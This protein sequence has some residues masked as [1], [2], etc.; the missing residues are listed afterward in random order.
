MT[1][2]ATEPSKR[3]LFVTWDGPQTSYLE[4][5]FLPI[6]AGLRDHG[7]GFQVLQFT[8]GP[9]GR[10]QASAAACEGAGIAYRAIEIW[11][12]PVGLGGLASALV[13][14]V[15]VRNAA[16]AFNAGLVM[17]R[18][19]LPA[20][21]TLAAWPDGRRGPRLVF[22]ADGLPI[23][24]RVDFAEWSRSDLRYR[25]LRRIE[26]AALHRAEVV[27]TRTHKAVE[28]LSGRVGPGA[29]ADRFH[30]VP[31]GRDTTLFRPQGPALRESVRTELGIPPAS[32]VVVLSGS[33]GPQYCIAETAALV[34][35]VQARRPDT[36]LLCLTGSPEQATAGLAAVGVDPQ[37]LHILSAA[38][39]DMP[40]YLGAADL[41]L[42]LRQPAFSMQG[43]FPI[44][45]GEFLL[46]GL[47]V[48]TTRG[49]GDIDCLIDERHG[50]F[51]EDLG[52]P[53]I[54]AAADWVVETF[55]P[56]SAGFASR[57]RA[58]GR[59]R[60]GLSDTIDAYAQALEAALAA[61]G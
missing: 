5:L 53:A 54:A 57:C 6:F 43:V 34:R 52:H 20:L 8:W 31:N 41:G 30:V 35:E 61:T 24:E 49:I 2:L 38:P 40:R 15:A 7:F 33:I 42:A 59:E 23:D 18:S 55:L 4:S 13:G 1:P 50:V 56:D 46:C 47:P 11:R 21:A 26:S 17:P 36:R 9:Q 37:R 60:F 14:S 51:L 12:R 58:I 27:L 32:L 10:R 19:T 3:V 44:K 29:P 28:I 39:A 16:S 22:D 25:I 45:I 48:V